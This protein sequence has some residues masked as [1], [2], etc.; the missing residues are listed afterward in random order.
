MCPKCKQRFVPPEGV[1][2]D[3]GLDYDAD[4]YLFRAVGCPQCEGSGYRGRIAIY[5]ILPVSDAIE[6]MIM[7]RASSRT[8]FRQAQNEGLVSL[9]EAGLSKVLAG[10]TSLEELTRVTMADK[11]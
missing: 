1:Q 5:E 11:E 9:R 3:L 8:L 2:R 7:E 6:A 4:R 10:L